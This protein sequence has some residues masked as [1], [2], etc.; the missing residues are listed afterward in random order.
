VFWASSGHGAVLKI[1]ARETSLRIEAQW[2]TN[3]GF[4]NHLMMV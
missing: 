1:A 3:A 4:D 2:H